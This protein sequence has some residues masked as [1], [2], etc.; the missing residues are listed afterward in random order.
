[1]VV[2]NLHDV[3]WMNDERIKALVDDMRQKPSRVYVTRGSEVSLAWDTM[4]RPSSSQ[5][6]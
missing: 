4:A 3:P 2:L 1:M 6:A 5:S